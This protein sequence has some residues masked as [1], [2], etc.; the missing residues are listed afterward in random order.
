[1]SN[2]NLSEETRGLIL[3]AILSNRKI[4]AIKLYRE[5]TGYGLKESKE[6]IDDLTSELAKE[7]P[8]LIKQNSNGCSSAIILLA[9]IPCFIYI[10]K[11]IA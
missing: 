4:D 8:E 5:G 10:I 6:Y 9:L 1:M 11:T 2:S 3:D 7:H